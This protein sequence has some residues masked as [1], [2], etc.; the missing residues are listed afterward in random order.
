MSPNIIARCT[1]RPLFLPLI[2]RASHKRLQCPNQ[3]TLQN[4]TFSI[5]YGPSM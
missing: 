1:S 4:K 2:R 5:F 3:T